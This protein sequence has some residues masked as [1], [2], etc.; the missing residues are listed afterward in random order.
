MWAFADIGLYNVDICRCG[1][2]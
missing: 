1:S 2:M